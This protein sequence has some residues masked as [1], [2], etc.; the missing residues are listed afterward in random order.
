M[1]YKFTKV[2]KIYLPALLQKYL[3]SHGL[4]ALGTKNRYAMA[5]PGA[6]PGGRG[7]EWLATPLFGLV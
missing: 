4:S 5:S 6:D 3:A 1:C 7:I 2:A